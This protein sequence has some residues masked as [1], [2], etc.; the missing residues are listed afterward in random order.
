M[1]TE[2]SDPG[3]ALGNPGPGYFH[4]SPQG[5]Q[6]GPSVNFAPGGNPYSLGTTRFLQ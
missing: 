1:A 5:I 2:T 6:S 3:P 4:S